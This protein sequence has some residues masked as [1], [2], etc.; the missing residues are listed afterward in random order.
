MA[1]GGGGGNKKRYQYCTDLLGGI[2]YFRALQG[3]SGR[4]PFRRQMLLFRVTSSK[5]E[6]RITYFQRGLW[7]G[8]ARGR[9][10]G[11]ER[12]HTQSVRRRRRQQHDDE[13]KRAARA[14]SLVLMSELSA[15][16]QALEGAP[17]A[18]GNMATPRVTDPEKRAPWPA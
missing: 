4:S 16:R 9:C 7:V 2:L 3:H 10:Q 14:L 8:V 18:P 6:A 15:A 5:V 12:V 13:G 17:V 1:G 11:A